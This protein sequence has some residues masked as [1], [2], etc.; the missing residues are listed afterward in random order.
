MLSPGN[1][2]RTTSD[3]HGQSP[4]MSLRTALQ[5]P[6]TQRAASCERPLEQ[7]GLKTN[8]RSPTVALLLFASLERGREESIAA[9][10]RL[11][12]SPRSLLAYS[13]KK[14][15]RK[16][17]TRSARSPEM[18]RPPAERRW[19]KK[20]KRKKK[21]RT[22]RRRVDRREF[23]HTPLSLPLRRHRPQ[24]QPHPPKLMLLMLSPKSSCRSKWVCKAV[25]KSSTSPR[26]VATTRLSNLLLLE[27]QRAMQ[28]NCKCYLR[29]NFIAVGPKIHATVRK[30]ALPQTKKK[31]KKKRRSH[32]TD[33]CEK[34]TKHRPKSNIANSCSQEHEAR[35][36]WSDVLREARYPSR[37]VEKK[38]PANHA[39]NR[40]NATVEQPPITVTTDKLNDEHWNK[41]GSLIA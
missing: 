9:C 21:K 25:Q 37:K 23:P 2:R 20:K 26:Q 28:P 17:N 16:K 1:A 29:S 31:S 36:L 32:F 5:Q 4:K 19:G 7:P 13:D 12:V 3:P 11:T 34:D 35:K 10:W 6:T 22:F 30:P 39:E 8:H 33:P 38:T 27:K 14:K 40:P 18:Q 41:K 24:P 15:K